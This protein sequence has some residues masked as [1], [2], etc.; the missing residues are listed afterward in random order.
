MEIPTNNLGQYLY[1]F[2][3][4]YSNFNFSIHCIN[5][6]LK[7]PFVLLNNVQESCM[8]IIDPISSLNVAKSSFKVAQIKSAF[9][10]G[11]MIIRDVLYKQIS[12]SENNNQNNENIFL[13]ELFKVRNFF[14]L[15][16]TIN[17]K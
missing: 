5:V 17:I 4:F 7:V 8:M 12:K 14:E 2:F 10:K 9:S 1:G 6:T 3:G 13:E 11:M 16:E 15:N